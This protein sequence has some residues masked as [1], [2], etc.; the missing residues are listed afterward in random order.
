[1]QIKN[2]SYRGSMGNKKIYSSDWKKK[3]KIQMEGCLKKTSMI[4]KCKNEKKRRFLRGTRA[5]D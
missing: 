2:K 1:M 5:P 3:K 4:G